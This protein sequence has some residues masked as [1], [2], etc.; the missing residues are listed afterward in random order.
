MFKSG[1]NYMISKPTLRLSK[2]IVDGKIIRH[3][4]GLAFI[5]FLNH[6]SHVAQLAML[7]SFSAGELVEFSTCIVGQN[8]GD[9]GTRSIRDHPFDRHWPL[10]LTGAR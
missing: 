5:K 8:T 3:Q 4:H 6:S 2:S 7:G 10:T 9:P 1:A